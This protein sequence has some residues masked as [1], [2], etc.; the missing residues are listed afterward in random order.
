[1][2]VLLDFL[3]T[4]HL[5]C[6]LFPLEKV[7][8]WWVGIYSSLFWKVLPEMATVR[9][10]QQKLFSR[11]VFEMI[12]RSPYTQEFKLVGTCISPEW[13][14]SSI[15]WSHKKPEHKQRR[16]GT[17]SSWLFKYCSSFQ[18]AYSTLACWWLTVEWRKI[19]KS[20]SPLWI[21]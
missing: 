6:M 2:L 8:L 1:M 18:K 9:N 21:G 15:V 10:C 17:V 3:S 16:V 19:T 14:Y 20:Y 7:C 12:S 11:S 4:G 5:Y 13:W